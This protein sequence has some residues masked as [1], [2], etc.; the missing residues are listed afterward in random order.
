VA[1]KSRLPAGSSFPDISLYFTVPELL[2][3]HPSLPV[4]TIA[5]LVALAKAKPNQLNFA[6][7][8]AGGPPHLAVELLKQAAGVEMVHIAYKGMGPALVDLIAGNVQLS[9]ADLPVLIPHVNAGRLRPLAVGVPKRAAAL[10]NVPT[11]AEA[12][13]PQV[14]AYNWCGLFA[15]ASTPAE[16]VARLNVEVLRTVNTPDMRAFFQA[17]GG[18]GTA[19][20]PDQLAALLRSELE[21]WAKVVK[22]ANIRPD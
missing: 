11:T 4:K 19:G 5:E 3:V 20:S 2:V 14:E 18:E 8:G 21:K 10:P 22:A 13:F 1:G 6:S 15:P 17:R 9:F 7:A 16:I 12:G